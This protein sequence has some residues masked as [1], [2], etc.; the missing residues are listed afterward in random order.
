MLPMFRVRVRVSVGRVEQLGTVQRLLRR[1]RP[2]EEVKI[3]YGLT[4]KI[5]IVFVAGTDC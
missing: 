4:E 5:F 1:R 2:A 3:F